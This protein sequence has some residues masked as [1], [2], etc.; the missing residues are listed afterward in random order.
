M[1][2]GFLEVEGSPVFGDPH[3][4]AR[5]PGTGKRLQGAY[6]GGQAAACGLRGGDS[7]FSAG[8]ADGTDFAWEHDREFVR[9]VERQRRAIGEAV[10]A[11]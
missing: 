5:G 10:W 11:R 6:S 2:G 3:V 4:R 8:E 1:P 7:S 9:S